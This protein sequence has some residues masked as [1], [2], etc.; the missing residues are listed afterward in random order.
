MPTSFLPTRVPTRPRD[1][2]LVDPLTALRRDDPAGQ[3]APVRQGD[4]A[5]HGRPAGQ[6][7]AAGGDG[8]AIVARRLTRAAPRR[9]RATPW[10]AL[11]LP[12]LLAACATTSLPPSPQYQRSTVAAEAEY[13]SYLISGSGTLQGQALQTLAD[14][15]R[16]PVA[17]RSVTLDPATTIGND[18]WRVAGRSWADRLSQPPSEG[19]AKARRTAL[20]DAEGRFVFRNLPAGSYLLRTDFG[21]ASANAPKGLL[22]RRIT[23][24]TT[25]PIVLD[26]LT[27]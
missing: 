10:L 26:D 14:G 25:G 13:Q 3:D 2:V 6:V 12:W 20:T 11:S 27:N 23:V 19:F 17:G 8:A 22:G 4:P 18:W 5:G 7:R 15:R 16:G 24:P 9:R 21:G 1:D